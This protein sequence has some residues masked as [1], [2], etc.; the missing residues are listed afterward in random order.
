MY[1]L[2]E[3]NCHPPSNTSGYDIVDKFRQAVETHGSIIHFKAYLDVSLSN[4]PK[5]A[6]LY[7][8]FQD[9][10]VTLAHCPHSGR[11]D[12]V[13]KMMLVDMISYTLYN[14]SPLTIVLITGDR[15]FAY[16]ISS[17]R[18]RG[19]DVIVIVPPSAHNS[20]QTLGT[21]ALN[22]QSDVINAVV[23]TTRGLKCGE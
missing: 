13:D 7:S 18:L 19:Y 1:G 9:A 23:G 16:G 20:I 17:L 3:E 6:K 10:G 11:K 21:F 5:S 12:V 22:W 15:D 14:S 8:E 4:G 2:L